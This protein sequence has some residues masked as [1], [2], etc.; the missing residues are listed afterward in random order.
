MTNSMEASRARRAVAGDSRPVIRPVRIPMM[1]ASFKPAP[2]WALK[3]F[4]SATLPSGNAC[5][6]TSPFVSVPSTST[7]STLMLR[8]RRRAFEGNLIS[9]N[10]IFSHS[11][12]Q[13]QG[14]EVVDV[15]DA[16]EAAGAVHDEHGRNFLFFHQ[17]QR[18]RGEFS[19]RQRDGV[20]RHAIAPRQLQHVLLALLHDAAKIAIREE[21]E[22]AAIRFGHS[23][24]AEA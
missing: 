17:A 2:S 21:S 11:S 12:K 18:A 20:G 5:K 13:L 14:P 24:K 1:L 16:F 19:A 15:H 7:R 3:T 4:I 9:R 6:Q 22:Q 10:A 8:A 23:R